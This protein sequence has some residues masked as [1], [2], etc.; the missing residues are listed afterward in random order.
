MESGNTEYTRAPLSSTKPKK[1]AEALPLPARFTVKIGSASEGRISGCSRKPFITPV[2][3]NGTSTSEEPSS[4]SV[5]VGAVNVPDENPTYTSGYVTPSITPVPPPVLNWSSVAPRS[6]TG[7][8]HGVHEAALPMK[9]SR[10]PVNENPDPCTSSCAT[11]MS[12]WP[13][14][15]PEEMTI[16]SARPAVG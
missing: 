9:P 14:M 11:E 15:V 1:P 3:V 12:T 5:P 4:V 10:P 13:A 7:D 2:K 8:A 6:A 16:G